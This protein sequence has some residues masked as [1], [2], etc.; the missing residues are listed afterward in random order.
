[1][2]NLDLLK[3]AGNL[4]QINSAERQPSPQRRERKPQKRYAHQGKALRKMAAAS[5]AANRQHGKKAKRELNPRQRR[6][7]ERQAAHDALSLKEK[8]DKVLSRPGVS[9]REIMRLLKIRSQVEMT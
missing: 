8:F 6:A 2:S 5:R 3:I 9:G 4:R 7:M 1:M